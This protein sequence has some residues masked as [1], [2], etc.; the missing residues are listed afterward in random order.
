MKSVTSVSGGKTSAY[1][2]IHFPTDIYVFALI[3]T[4]HAQSQPKDK[5]LAKE[6]RSRIPW[7][8][9]TQEA[10]QTLSN[11][12]RLE[13]KL[14]KEIKWVASPFTMDDFIFNRTDLPGYR[15]GKPFLPN[16][17]HRF[18]TQQL[19]IIPIFNWLYL[20][21]YEDTPLLMHIGYRWDEEKRVNNWTC[22]NDFY[23]LPKAC[24]K[25]SRRTCYERIEIRTTDFP[26]FR[27]KIN[28]VKIKEYWDKEGWTFPSVSNCRFCFFHKDIQLQIQAQKEPENLEWWKEIEQNTGRNFGERSLTERLR[29]PLLKVFDEELISCSCSD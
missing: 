28:H 21:H 6:M 27:E 16:K 12:L 11:L 25:T 8:I 26:L 24:T 17:R 7:A 19:K 9:A 1:M 20:N 3:L 18:C 15:S 14:G 13:Q 29:Q 4:N 5:G 2:A 23:K 22:D 10:D